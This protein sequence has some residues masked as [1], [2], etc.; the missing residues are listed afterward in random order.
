MT[1]E[2]EE[3]RRVVNLGF[4]NVQMLDEKVDPRRLGSD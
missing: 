2:P 1:I 3:T 4:E